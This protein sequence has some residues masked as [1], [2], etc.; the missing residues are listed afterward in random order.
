MK[1]N[2]CAPRTLLCELNFE[3]GI[4][5]YSNGQGGASGSPMTQDD[6]TFDGWDD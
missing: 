1:I 2:Y 6:E 3:R 5:L 4:L